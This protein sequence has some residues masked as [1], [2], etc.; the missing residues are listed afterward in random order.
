MSVSYL[1]WLSLLSSLLC[2]DFCWDG[3]LQ[4]GLTRELE[5]GSAGFRDVHGFT[6]LRF[7]YS[8]QAI[9]GELS[10][11]YSVSRK[12]ALII[13]LHKFGYYLGCNSKKLS[14]QKSKIIRQNNCNF[15]CPTLYIAR[16]TLFWRTLLHTRDA[17][18]QIDFKLV[19]TM[20][21][22]GKHIANY[23]SK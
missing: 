5:D 20:L 14:R 7:I 22:L 8:V 23:W 4:R 2:G 3:S 21:A 16:H 12:N 10:H 15:K 19:A 6:H 18:I 17:F 11:F 9:A 13:L 1:C